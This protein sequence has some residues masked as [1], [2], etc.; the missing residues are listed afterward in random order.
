MLN[1]I[2]YQLRGD[3]DKSIYGVVY[4]LLFIQWAV[5]CAKMLNYSKQCTFIC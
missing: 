4:D 5:C 3:T 1:K 2:E